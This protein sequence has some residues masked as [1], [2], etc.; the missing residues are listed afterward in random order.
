[1]KTIQD[2]INLREKRVKRGYLR[3]EEANAIIMTASVHQLL[4]G[5]RTLHGDGDNIPMWEKF[6]KSGIITKEQIKNLKMATTYMN[7]FLDGI[8]IDNLDRKSKQ[9]IAKRIAKWELRV[10]DDYQVKKLENMLAKSGERTLTL[11]EFFEFVDARLYADCKGCKKN[12][13]DCKLRDFYEANFI[14][15]VEDLGMIKGE[16]ACNCEYSY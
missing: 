10:V 3:Q 5:I 4:M 2:G 6:G 8:I 14:P 1:M 7:K 9:M 12:R 16:V 13:N 15:P 11:E